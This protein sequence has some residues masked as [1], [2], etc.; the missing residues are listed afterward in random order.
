MLVEVRIG[1]GCHFPIEPHMLFPFFQYLPLAMRRVIG[2]HWPFSFEKLRHGDPERDAVQVRLMTR[3]ELQ[4][5][6]PDANILVE[7]FAGLVKSLLAVKIP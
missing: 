1:N 6:F 7:R 5:C 4:D 3:K 2:R